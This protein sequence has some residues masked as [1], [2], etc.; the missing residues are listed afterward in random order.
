[1][2]RLSLET[3]GESVKRIFGLIFVGVGFA[4]LVLAPLFRF[5][6]GPSA[7]QTPLDTNVTTI[8]SGTVIKQLDVSKFAAGDPD[9]YYPPNLPATS[10]RYTKGDIVAEEQDTAKSENLAVFDTFSRTNIESD[11]RLVTAGESTYAFGRQNSV[12]ANCCGANEGGKT[13]NFTGN[14]LLKFPFFTQQQ[15]YNVWDAQILQSVPTEFIGEQVVGGLNT[16]KFQYTVEPTM[17]PDSSQK[18]PAKA[19]GKTGPDVEVNP[20]YKNTVVFYIEPLTGQVVANSTVAKITFRE[21]TD[22]KDLVTFLEMDFPLNPNITPEDVSSISSTAAQ[23]KL[24][25][26]TLPVVFLVLG[27]IGIIVGFLLLRSAAK[28]PEDDNT[29]PPAAGDPPP[30][31]V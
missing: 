28:R 16:Y 19:V 26:Y 23:L 9:P 3:K 25:M 8:G 11:G 1:M 21:G 12:L 5:Y 13:V 7:A 10:T 29:T 30:V 27:I 31:T 22:P 4:L 6:V 17:V 18:V 15:T 20:W 24:V 14:V 2:A